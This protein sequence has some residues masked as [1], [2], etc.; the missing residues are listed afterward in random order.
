MTTQTLLILAAG[1]G[2]RF[3]GPKQ[4]EPIGPDG[5]TIMEYSIHDAQTAGFHKI[6]IVLRREHEHSFRHSIGARIEKR[7]SVH[8]VFQELNELPRGYFAPPLRNKPWGTTQAILAAQS[9][10]HEPFAVIN[11]FDFYGANTYRALAHHLQSGSR[12]YAMV[13]FVLRN[14]LSDFGAVARGVCQV[15]DMNLLRE[16]VELKSIERE[17]AHAINIGADGAETKLAG[18]EVVSMNMWGFT[19]VVFGQLE[20]QF[21]KFLERNG[22]D[23]YAECSI[24]TT[25]N[26]LLQAGVAR[27]KVLRC[28]DSWF[29]VTYYEDQPRATEHLRQL[30]TEGYY[31]R[32]L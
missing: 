16:V 20:E 12:D 7:A 10:I 23:L 14:T 5:E 29:G 13:G 26:E 9:A 4:T 1:M 25:V 24:P 3:G 22:T 30:I 31:P 28:G 6:V 2:S 18:D 11:A 8:Y 32:R 15:D 27:V 21:A 17:R 19:P